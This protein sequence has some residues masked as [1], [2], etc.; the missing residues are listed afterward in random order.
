M[1]LQEIR[2]KVRRLEITRLLISGPGMV[3]W[4]GFAI[5]FA[6]MTPRRYEQGRTIV[7]ASGVCMILISTYMAYICGRGFFSKRLAPDAGRK[8]AVES[9][10]TFYRWKRGMNLR[11]LVLYC[12]M[13][14]V[15]LPL[16]LILTWL[17]QPVF[18][19]I[20]LVF[21][22]S[23]YLLLASTTYFSVK[24]L[25]HKLQTELD[26]VEALSKDDGNAN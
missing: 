15:L 9:L 8:T 4:L 19:T 10:R 7:A 3:G 18:P 25:A 24:W 22:G 13:F 21:L 17:Q 16:A 20:K 2:A 23:G 1:S 5:F 6:V 12:A 26:T 11:I 14:F